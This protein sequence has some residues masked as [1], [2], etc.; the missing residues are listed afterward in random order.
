MQA[1]HRSAPFSQSGVG[2]ALIH[3]YLT[4]LL[5]LVLGGILIY[6]GYRKIFDLP[7]MADAIENYRVLPVA[8]VNVFGILMPALEIVTGLCLI[9][10]LFYDGA[11]AIA[12][13]LFLL[14]VI[15]VQAAIFRGLDIECGC[16]G[17][18]DGSVVGMKTL[19]RDVLFLLGT[20]PLW[21]ARLGS[22]HSEPMPEAT[23]AALSPEV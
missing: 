22:T 15:V 8:V 20:V 1:T 7:A 18:S 10:G 13:G 11:L 17:T 9:I 6:A 16:F 14:F 2:Q 3:P 4:I 5:R 21:M 23:S 19:I 12:T